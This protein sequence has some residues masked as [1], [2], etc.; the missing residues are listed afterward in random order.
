MCIV[1]KKLDKVYMK[2]RKR[3][4]ESDAHFDFFNELAAS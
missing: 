1:K 3:M 4:H 2:Q